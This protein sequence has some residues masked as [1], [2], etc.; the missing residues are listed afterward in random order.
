MAFSVKFNDV[1]LS[2]IVDGFTAITRNI[3]A[4]WTNTVQPNPIIG[5][6]F[7]QNSI[8]S[9]SITVNFIANVKLDRF[10]SVRKALASALNVKQPAALIFDDDPNQVWWAVPDGTPTLD[11]SS[12]YQAVGSITF[13]VPSG[14]SES[15]ETNI[16]NASNSGD[17]LGTITNN[18]GGSVDVE[19]NNTGNLETFPTIEITNVHENGYIAI[20]GQNGAIEIGKRQEADGATSPMSENLYFSTSDTNF[21]DFKDVA[22]GTPNPQ[23]DWLATN[24]KL[25]FQKDGLR[26]KEK[27]IVG[28]RQ[29]VAGGMKVMTLPADSNGHVGAVN[30]YSY[31]NLFAWAGAFG[32]TGLL[33]VLFTDVNDKLVA[34]YG[35][36]KGD[37]SGNKAQVKFWCGG[38]N[39][40]ELGSKDFISNN[41]EGNGAGD[42]NNTQFNERNG[43]TDFVK[44]GEKL[45]FYWKGARIPFY[46]PDLANV[47][48][49][50]VYIYIG[51]YTQSNKFITNLSM[52]NISCR[53][54]NIQ[55]WE[56]I[57][58]RY[59]KHSKFSIDSY[60]GTIS[61]D[62]V[63]SANEKINGAKFLVFPPGESE[64][65]LSPSSWVTIAPDVEIS[66]E[67]NIL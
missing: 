19:I 58:N 66:W 14:V 29:G 3:G 4:G 13:L 27:G 49:A 54:D 43:S 8:N 42:M 18:S 28:S 65:I 61:I 33:Q 10:T 67:E 34:G 9:K 46:I 7:T 31:F 40:R 20:A 52:R 36:S 63:S 23:N 5:A 37:M 45:E 59:A 53:K 39:P 44:T 12:F 16:L 48:I 21:S 38:S 35:I 30:F 57:P 32:Q 15:V 2:T 55:K 64:I 60:Y 11:E 62:G 17:R 1:D 22:P 25:E 26:L 50:K 24:G 6:D 47:E 56:D 41:G 51:Q